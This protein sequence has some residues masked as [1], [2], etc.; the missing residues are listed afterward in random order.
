VGNERGIDHYFNKVHTPDFAHSYLLT[1]V[2]NADY[3]DADNI[4][5]PSKGDLGG[6]LQFSYKKVNNYQWQVIKTF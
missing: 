5:G 3:V 1:N 2:L 6:Y 4:K